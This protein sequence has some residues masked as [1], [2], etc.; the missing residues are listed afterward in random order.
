MDCI[1]HGVA[2]SQTRLSNFHTTM[3]KA[4]VLDYE[5]I[6]INTPVSQNLHFIL[7]IYFSKESVF[8]KYINQCEWQVMNLIFK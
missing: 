8:I 3:E 2:K 1:V 4:H 5:D 6:V 7:H